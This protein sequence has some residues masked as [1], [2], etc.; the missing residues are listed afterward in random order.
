MIGE[1][2]NRRTERWFGPGLSRFPFV[3]FGES[4]CFEAYPVPENLLH[5]AAGL[6]RECNHIGCNTFF[7]GTVV[8]VGHV[9]AQDALDSV[10]PK[11]RADQVRIQQR[12]HS[13]KLVISGNRKNLCGTR[14]AL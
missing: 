1:S 7:A 12:R 4:V 13:P 6:V 8:H 3:D 14:G 11:V 2:S 9:A 10:R 5:R